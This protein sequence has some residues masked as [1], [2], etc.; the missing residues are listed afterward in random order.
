M[1]KTPD[2][3]RLQEEHTGLETIRSDWE[4]DWRE[5]SNQ[6]LP[7]RGINTLKVGR[8]G[9]RV[10]RQLISVKAVNTT[11]RKSLQTLSSILQ[12]GLTSA[13]RS[14]FALKFP[15]DQAPKQLVLWI[16]ESAKILLDGFTESNFYS[17]LDT[18]YN[19]YAGFGTAALAMLD[20]EEKVF[21]FEPLT[22]GEY[23][24][25]LNSL[26]LPERFF[27]RIPYTLRQIVDQFGTENLSEELSL[28][29]KNE[30]PAAM[31]TLY[32]VVQAIYREEIGDKPITTV[33]FIDNTLGPT[34]SGLEVPKPLLVGGYYE[35]PIAI[36]RWSVLGNDPYG[37]GPGHHSLPNCKRL[38][39]MERA[40]LQGTHKAIDPPVNVP[41]EMRGKIDLLPSG[42]NYYSNLEKRVTSVY[43]VRLD[44]QGVTAAIQ[45]VETQ[46][47]RDFFNDLLLTATRDPDASPL[48]TGEVNEKERERL[49]QMAPTV[50]RLQSEVFEMIIERGFNMMLRAG[51]LPPLPQ[52]LI[53]QV[54]KF[55]IRITSPLAQAQKQLEARSIE[56]FM[57][58]VGGAAQ[59][60]PTA[61][62]NLE[63]DEAIS[64]YHDITG[65]PSRILA[66]KAS[67]LRKRQAR[68]DQQARQQQIQEQ[69]ALR[70]A[71]TSDTKAK[72][73][74][75]KI[76]SEAGVNLN[77]QGFTLPQ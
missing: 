60:D 6:I 44:F 30:E 28:R 20:E 7:G 75:A 19:E 77:E 57:A 36:G 48:R 8:G 2:V 27:R 12:S 49:I 43:E 26:N 34:T 39:E 35:F 29:V 59:F 58:F 56:S 24:Y 76:L 11:P 22:A 23:A 70:E 5:I 9:R 14:W 37:I 42:L 33:Y 61:L 51:K 16:E 63:T 13:A 32:C 64:E 1:A 73:E 54:S 21:R 62:D 31:N 65:A 50:Q 47:Q 4:R 17:E 72:A 10:R 25:S 71:D 18:F 67:V 52:N 45:R 69:A 74:T 46:I 66:S 41:S 53:E 15:N 38:Q 68:A 3:K 40:F 55:N